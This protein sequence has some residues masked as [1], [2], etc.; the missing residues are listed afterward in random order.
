MPSTPAVEA[1]RAGESGAGFAVVADEVRNLAMRAAE[2]AKNT[3]TMIE[4]TAEKIKTG[5]EISEKNRAVIDKIASSALQTRDLI[6]E[7]ATASKEQAQGIEQINRA[8]SEMDKVVQRNA[9]N[10]EETASASEEMNAQ[11]EQMK[12]NVRELAALIHGRKGNRKKGGT[13][14]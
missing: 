13:K 9:A 1:A 3:A 6:D 7:I 8:V 14:G 11:S 12:A 5:S 2:A 4:G 10:S